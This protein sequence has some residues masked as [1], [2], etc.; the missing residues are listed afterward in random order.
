MPISAYSADSVV[1]DGDIRLSGLG[2]L[3]FSDGSVQ[4]SASIQGPMGDPG[5][6]GPPGPPGPA[7]PSYLSITAE[8]YYALGDSITRGGGSISGDFSYADFL[9][10]RFSFNSFTKLAVGGA[11]VMPTVGHG[12][13]ATQV[14]AIGVEADVITVLIGVNDYLWGNPVGDADA[15]LQKEYA[16]LDKSL[17]FAEAYRYCLETIKRNHEYARIYV[18]LP[19]QTSWQRPIPLDQFRA[20]EIKIASFLSIPVIHADTESGLWS[21]GTSMPDGLH[22]NDN[23]YLMLG[24]YI[25]R[26]MIS[27]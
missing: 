18:I 17:S 24:N 26:R 22:P 13:L 5:P 15:V 12:E 21:G 1:I 19:I 3:L 2:R 16:S 25:A 8:S 14:S 23:G 27:L 7:G 11:T 9:N 4:S 6:M 10:S 20:A